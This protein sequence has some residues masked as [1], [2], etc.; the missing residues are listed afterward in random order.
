MAFVEEFKKFA[1]RGNVVDMA[2]GVVIGGAFGPIVKSAVDDLM[3]PPIGLLLGNVDFKDLFLV[4][5]RGEKAVAEAETLAKARE[6]G[7]VV[8]AYGSFFN[9]IVSFVIVA[10]AVFLLV[11]AVNRLAAKEAPPPPP[12]T[13][14]CP[15][16]CGA[17]PMKAKRC[18]LCTSEVAPAA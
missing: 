1:M 2:V 5:H 11:K 18:P 15:M 8:L 14:D 13:R 17:I 6:Q 4:I 7:D 10:F 3:M 16:C 12:N 9:S